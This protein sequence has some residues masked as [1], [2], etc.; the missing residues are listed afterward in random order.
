M[1][2]HAATKKYIYPGKLNSIALQKNSINKILQKKNRIKFLIKFHWIIIIFAMLSRIHITIWNR[3]NSG[4][5][6]ERKKSNEMN[7]T[8]F[9]ICHT[10][11][12]K[13]HIRS[14]YM[15]LTFVFCSFFFNY[16]S[17]LRERCMHHNIRC[18]ISLAS[19]VNYSL[20]ML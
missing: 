15:H 3:T 20:T 11:E 9:N 14:S 18:T 1:L 13:L 16:Q 2:Y 17:H 6:R 10:K 19:R 7:G 12:K 4:W 8:W 5:K